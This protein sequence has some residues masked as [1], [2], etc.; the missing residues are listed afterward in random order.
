MG[1]RS[2]YPR[3]IIFDED[4]DELRAFEMEQKGWATVH[5]ELENGNR[6]RLNFYEP[7]RLGQELDDGIELG[8]PCFV[9]LNLIVVPRVTV[10]TIQQSVQYL[11]RIGF[12]DD[13]KPE[14]QESNQEK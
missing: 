1:E 2:V 9:E 13:L 10:E 7:V 6:Y 3:V 12:F 8:K 11:L 14:Q 5:V 4:F